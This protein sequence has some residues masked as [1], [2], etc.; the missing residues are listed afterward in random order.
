MKRVSIPHDWTGEPALAVLNW[1]QS[2]VDAIWEQYADELIEELAQR[3]TP[4]SRASCPSEGSSWDT[5]AARVPGG[6]QPSWNTAT[7]CVPRSSAAYFLGLY[8]PVGPRIRPCPIASWDPASGQIPLPF[9]G[10]LGG[11]PPGNE[12]GTRQGSSSG[13]WPACGSGARRGCW[14]GSKPM[15]AMGLPQSGQQRSASATRCS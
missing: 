14:S 5:G 13:R 8:V 12:R 6:A 15:L 9:P 4:T 11:T 7:S 3:P 2:V 10:K 1:L